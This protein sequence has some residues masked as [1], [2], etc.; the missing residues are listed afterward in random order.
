[1]PRLPDESAGFLEVLGGRDA[2]EG[3]DLADEEAEIIESVSY[4]KEIV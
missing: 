4:E 1:M 3:E 2:C